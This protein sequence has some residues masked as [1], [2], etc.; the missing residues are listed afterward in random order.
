[1]KLYLVRHAETNYNVQRLANADPAVDVH[2]TEK[3]IEQARQVA[4]ALQHA[5]Y[6]VVYISQLRRT[7]QT[8]EI[9]NAP[10][11]KD[12]VV[13]ERL[14]DNKTGF[15]SKP[16]AEWEEA[17]N[18]SGDRLNASFND[19]ESLNEAARRAQEFIEDL[20]TK[21]HAAVLVVTH[22]FITKAIYGYVE[23][24]SPEE[25]YQYKLTQGTYAVFEI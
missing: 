19:G 21:P 11:Q 23:D 13:D 22:G 8:A 16:L 15:E 3:G 4:E 20:K 17:L 2:L 25:A 10:H 24:K 9:I 5:D 14:N 18:E 1:M 12:L 6:E 7:R